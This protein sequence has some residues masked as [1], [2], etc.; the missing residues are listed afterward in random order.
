MNTLLMSRS[1]R[2]NTHSRD[3]VETLNKEFCG[4]VFMA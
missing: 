1:A 3:L 4:N 2:S